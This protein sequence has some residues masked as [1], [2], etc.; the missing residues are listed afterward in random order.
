M[1][2]MQSAQKYCC[3]FFLQSAHLSYPYF[4]KWYPGMFCTC[5]PT[6]QVIV[7]VKIY[8]GT[9]KALWCSGARKGMMKLSLAPKLLGNLVWVT[10]ILFCKI[11]I[12][13]YTFDALLCRNW[14]F[15]PPHGMTLWI[16]LSHLCSPH[17]EWK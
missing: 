3:N 13:S 15:S 14:P 1:K 10:V 4:L 8:V 12:P 2:W 9:V 17:V 7:L 5:N 11:F 6:Y 16:T